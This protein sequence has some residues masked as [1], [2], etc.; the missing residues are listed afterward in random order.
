MLV[1]FGVE[2]EVLS[3]MNTTTLEVIT[4][5]KDMCAGRHNKTPPIMGGAGCSYGELGGQLFGFLG[6]NMGGQG[7]R[8]GNEQVVVAVVVEVVAALRIR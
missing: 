8:V 5:V 7:Q 4:Q 3:Q 2:C 6:R 1:P